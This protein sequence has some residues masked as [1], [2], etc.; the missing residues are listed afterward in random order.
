MDTVK[1]IKSRIGEILLEGGFLADSKRESAV[2]RI[3]DIVKERNGPGDHW[4]T[5]EWSEWSNELASLIPEDQ[6][7]ANPEAAQEHIILEYFRHLT[8]NVACESCGRA[9][10]LKCS[11]CD[12]NE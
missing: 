6:E 11:V 4:T 3:L 5:D 8:K 12:N 1:D 9:M 10:M 7:V 2:E